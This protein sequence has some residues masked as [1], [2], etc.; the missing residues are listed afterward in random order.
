MLL[1]AGEEEQFSAVPISSELPSQEHPPSL[2]P[3]L[4]SGDALCCNSTL[5]GNSQLGCWQ[6]VCLRAQEYPAALSPPH[7]SSLGCSVPQFG[8]C[9][10][11]LAPDN[12]RRGHSGAQPCSGLSQPPHPHHPG[13]VGCPHKLPNWFPW[14]FPSL[15]SVSMAITLLA[16]HPGCW[17]TARG[18]L[19]TPA[20]PP[21]SPAALPCQ[22]SSRASTAPCT[23]PE[24]VGC[25]SSTTFLQTP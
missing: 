7:H 21:V 13:P 23:C 3:V 16:P 9:C 8:T 12:P 11:S 4:L 24:P 1:L 18:S 22:Q 15:S 14:Q 2:T 6:L 25:L 20:A 10:S 19:S 17:G 5:L